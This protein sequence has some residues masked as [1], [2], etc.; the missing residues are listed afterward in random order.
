MLRLELGR[1]SRRLRSRKPYRLCCRR[2]IKIKMEIK[3]SS[4]R[5]DKKFIMEKVD[6]KVIILQEK[7][8]LSCFLLF[9]AS[10]LL[11]AETKFS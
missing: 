1:H 4:E 11:Q 9:E 2:F 8:S 5:I 7:S 6:N 10:F 3:L